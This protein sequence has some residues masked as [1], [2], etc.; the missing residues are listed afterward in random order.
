MEILATGVSITTS[1]T[2]AGATL[3]NNAGGVKPKFVRIASTSAAYVRLGTGTQTAV[4]TDMLVQP[5]DSIVLA[6][7]GST[8]AAALQVTAAGV[9]QISP[10]EG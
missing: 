8:H 1:G 3:S 4:A 9:V 5:G 6:T 7:N 10:I 2:S